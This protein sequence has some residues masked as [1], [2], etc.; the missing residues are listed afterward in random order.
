MQLH[1]NFTKCHGGQSH[2]WLQKWLIW[3]HVANAWIGMDSIP[4]SAFLSLK[5][6]NS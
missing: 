3:S 2:P 5:C 6:N 4:R 1:V